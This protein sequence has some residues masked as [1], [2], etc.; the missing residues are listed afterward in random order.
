MQCNSLLS[1]MDFRETVD[2]LM[3]AQ[4]S[5]VGAPAWVTT[6][7]DG[8]MRWLAPLGVDGQVTG[9]NLIV[10][11][12]PRS[13]LQ[14]FSILLVYTVAVMRLDYGELERHLNHVVR[15][16]AFPTGVLAGWIEGPHCH[17]WE[18]NRELAWNRPSKELEFA[19]ILPVAVRGFDNAFRWF[20][21]E[22][23]IGLGPNDVPQLPPKDLLL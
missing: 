4:K 13:D 20:C 22:A 12:Y 9:M 19:T 6:D 14:K 15:G 16:K 7:Y 11:S 17:S 3:A 23:N 21:G 5:I 2:L 10:D 1:K 8:Q 18:L